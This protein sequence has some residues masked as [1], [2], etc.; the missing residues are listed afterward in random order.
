MATRLETPSA[1]RR[2]TIGAVCELLRPEFTD[3]SISKIRYL[4]DQGLL[5]PHRTRGGYR[6]FSETD[7]DRLRRILTLQRDAFLP[8][9]VIRDELER[10]PEA[11]TPAG[12]PRRRRALPRGTV[13]P[14]RDEL[15]RATGATPELL[16]ELEDFSLVAE[17]EGRFRP[18]DEQ[19]VAAAVGL[20]R[21]GVGAR[22]L[23]T[24]HSAIQ[25][26]AGLLEQ[27]LAPSLRSRNPE[28]QSAGLEDLETLA[29]LCADLTEAV[30]QRD[31]GGVAR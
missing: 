9:K 19:I 27:L 5:E 11:P 6:L 24:I 21:Y 25:R 8:L 31:L 2:L 18:E 30:L 15:E 16:R 7:V 10:A 3:L 28:R 12:G 20:N 22:H 23:P 17:R 1:P 4:E 14:T 29:G 13:G 26:E